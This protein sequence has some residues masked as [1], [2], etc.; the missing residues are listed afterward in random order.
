MPCCCIILLLCCCE[1]F[2]GL[3][4]VVVCIDPTPVVGVGPLVDIVIDPVIVCCPGGPPAVETDIPDVLTGCCW[5]PG[6]MLLP[7]IPGPVDGP[8]VVVVGGVPRPPAMAAWLGNL[9][10]VCCCIVLNGCC[11]SVTVCPVTCCN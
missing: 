10:I 9:W 3:F 2:I 8:L 7:G 11:A 1:G 6:G 5:L 4:A